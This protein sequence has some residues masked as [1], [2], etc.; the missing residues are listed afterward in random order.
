MNF[1][2]PSTSAQPASTPAEGEASVANDFVLASTP[3]MGSPGLTAGDEEE[4]SAFAP[5]VID[6][7]LASLND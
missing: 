7:I 2:P 5:E 3:F 4:Q 1:A 6:A